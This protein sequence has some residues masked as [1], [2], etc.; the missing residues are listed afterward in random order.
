MN[1]YDILLSGLFDAGYDVKLTTNPEASERLLITV[2]QRETGFSV[3]RS[4]EKLDIHD[5][6]R[7]TRMS[8]DL[9]RELMI[10][11]QLHTLEI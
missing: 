11:K 8:L 2:T 4:I 9:R 3:I 1:R 7:L 10:L 5:L 6:S